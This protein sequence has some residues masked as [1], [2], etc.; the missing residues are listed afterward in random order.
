MAH[1]FSSG[2]YPS[3]RAC[4]GDRTTGPGT[5]RHEDRGVRVPR[6]AKYGDT[7]LLDRSVELLW[8][9]GCDAV[10]IRDLEAVLDVKAPSIYRRFHS[11]DQLIARSVDRYVDRVVVGR[12]RRH[13]DGVDDPV[14]GLR[15]FFVSALEPAGGE[16][17]PRGCLLTVTAGQAAAAAPGVRRAV[18]DGLAVIESALSA[19][20][21]RAGEQGRTVPGSDPEL[22]ATSLLLAFE[23]LL[24]LARSGRPGLAAVVDQLL[25]ACFPTDPDRSHREDPTHE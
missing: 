17:L 16:L 21:H 18:A 5:V 20:V 10:S 9:D 12:I 7:D 3:S 25:A 24:V 14:E 8:R 1:V 11:R 6:P 4:T 13:L 15:S 19:Q 2:C 22:V 23:G